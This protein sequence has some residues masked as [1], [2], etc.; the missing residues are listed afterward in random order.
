M[1]H[2]DKSDLGPQM[3]LLQMCN[4]PGW[5]PRSPAG[6]TRTHTNAG[7]YQ[8]ESYPATGLHPSSTDVFLLSCVEL[9]R[10]ARTDPSALVLPVTGHWGFS[11]DL[12]QPTRPGI[13]PLGSEA[14]HKVCPCVLSQTTQPWVCVV[15]GWD[16]WMSKVCWVVKHASPWT[17]FHDSC[18]MIASSL[19][20]T[21]T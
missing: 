9:A 16:L 14:L 18:T 21:L 1:G 8:H 11:R 20:G 5:R 4:I 19:S 3:Y 10:K 6:N 12:A 17:L 13:A 2:T 7:L 15:R